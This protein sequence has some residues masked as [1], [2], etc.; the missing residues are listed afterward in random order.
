MINP[1]IEALGQEKSLIGKHLRAG[2]GVGPRF[3]KI[4]SLDHR[5]APKASE[6]RGFHS[7]V[8]QHECDHLDGILYPMMDD[9]DYVIR[10]KCDEV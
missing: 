9:F 2:P 8:V 3:T 5:M 1:E 7:R 10:R 4:A 6:L